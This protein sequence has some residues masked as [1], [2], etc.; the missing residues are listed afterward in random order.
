MTA[1]KTTQERARAP[2]SSRAQLRPIGVIRSKIKQRSQAPKQVIFVTVAGTASLSALR[3]ISF[4]VLQR[5]FPLFAVDKA[6]SAGS[7]PVIHQP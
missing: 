6:R 2:I 1:K 7:L 4:P 3:D 5:S